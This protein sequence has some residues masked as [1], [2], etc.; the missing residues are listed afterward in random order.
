MATAGEPNIWPDVR[1]I[2]S[3]MYDIYNR[4][5]CFLFTL[6]FRSFYYLGKC[7]RI[8]GTAAILTQGK[9]YTLIL[10]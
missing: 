10:T 8:C 5:S 4:V 6:N 2:N 1:L 7:V 3:P 9:I